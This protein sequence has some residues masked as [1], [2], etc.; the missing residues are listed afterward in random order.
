MDRGAWRATVHTHIA[1]CIGPK[2]T[3][4]NSCQHRMVSLKCNTFCLIPYKDSNGT[5]HKK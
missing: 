4:R 1:V 3:G 2:Y 5:Q